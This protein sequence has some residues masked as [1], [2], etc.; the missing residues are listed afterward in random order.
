MRAPFGVSTSTVSPFVSRGRS[1]ARCPLVTLSCTKFGAR[2]ST[3]TSESAP[4]RTKACRTI[5][6]SAL[7]FSAVYTSSPATSAVFT[8]AGAQST[9]PGRQKDTSPSTNRRRRGVANATSSVAPTGTGDT[10]TDTV[11]TIVATN[12]QRGEVF[13]GDLSGCLERRPGPNRAPSRVYTSCAARAPDL[14]KTPPLRSLTICCQTTHWL[15][16]HIDDP[17]SSCYVTTPCGL[18]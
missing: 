15:T 10:R 7:P 11:A 13:I 9:A 14:N 5:S 8:W 18:D 16:S 12:R 17:G 4:V 1:R 2:D 3:P 6:I